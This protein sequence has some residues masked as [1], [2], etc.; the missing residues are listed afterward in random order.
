MASATNVCV[1][2]GKSDGLL[3][4]GTGGCIFAI[5]D[6]CLGFRPNVDD[7]GNF[8]CPFCA[9]S[10]ALSHYIKIKEQMSVT[11]KQLRMFLHTDSEN[12]SMELS[13]SLKDKEKL[14][15]GVG[16]VD[17]VDRIANL[18]D[19][20]GHDYH[21]HNV[22]D[23]VKSEPVTPISEQEPGGVLYTSRSIVERQMEPTVEACP[24]VRLPGRKQDQD[25]PKPPCVGDDISSENGDMIPGEWGQT[26][27]AFKKQ[28]MEEIV[29][30]KLVMPIHSIPPG[31]LV[32]E[33]DNDNDEPRN[34][35]DRLSSRKRKRDNALISTLKNLSSKDESVSHLR[36]RKVPWT[37]QEEKKLKEG[38]QKFSNNGRIPWKTILDDGISV[39]ADVRTAEDLRSKW[40]NMCKGSRTL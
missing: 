14:F 12:P 17:G 1:K 34:S 38:L 35:A 19:G 21:F 39:F 8:R 32:S 5:H 7:T 36:R 10:R 2:C 24:S 20:K 29:V 16:F 27:G 26:E 40:K 31:G 18:E 23:P 9:H 3:F 28:V 6:S 37:L 11:L 15:S 33:S 25:L 22:T 4:C 13:D 30:P